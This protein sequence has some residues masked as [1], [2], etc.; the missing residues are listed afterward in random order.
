MDSS[1]LGDSVLSEAEPLRNVTAEDVS[2]SD[3]DIVEARRLTL[4]QERDIQKYEREI[5]QTEK[6]AKKWTQVQI[7][8]VAAI[9]DAE[10]VAKRFE[11]ERAQAEFQ[12]EL[13][14]KEAEIDAEM[15][16]IESECGELRLEIQAL[17]LELS[18][19][20][21]QR[22]R[23]LL[24]T[25]AEIATALR[26]REQKEMGHAAQIQKLQTTLTQITDKHRRDIEDLQAE[27]ANGD[28]LIEIEIERLSELVERARG[29]M[30]KLDE[31][32]SHRMS[33]A[34]A[35]VEMLRGEISSS[36]ERSQ[37]LREETEQMR[38]TLGQ[39]QQELFK[40]E[41]RSQVLTE[42]L[43]SSQEQKRL[44]RIEI[45]KLD[46]SIWN[47]RKTKLLRTE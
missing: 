18:E 31:V 43:G 41:E 15:R 30:Y 37:N 33:D 23:D 21:E 20:K 11:L 4:R 35:T 6:T 29:D 3:P 9:K 36:N 7:S 14:T 1:S 27:A 44:M 25:R 34:L 16:E 38:A 39:L 13:A 22:K 19:V 45:G 32:Q 8:T 47:S 40:A 10:L 12:S 24:A 2:G 17:E 26:D 42:Q 46:R 5:Q 28:K